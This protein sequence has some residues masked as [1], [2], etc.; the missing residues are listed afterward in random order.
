MYVELA[1]QAYPRVLFCIP[2]V[3][4]TNTQLAIDPSS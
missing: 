1:Q 3:N 2:Y 4:N